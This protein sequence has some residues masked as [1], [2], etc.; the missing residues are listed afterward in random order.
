MGSLTP[1]VDRFM[2]KVRVDE[3]TG[4]WIWTS[5]TQHRDPDSYG[6]F[7]DGGPVR[8]AD[9]RRRQMTLAHRWSYAHFKGPL[10]DAP[11]RSFA[12]CHTCDRPSC[13]NPDHL[14]LGTYAENVDDARRKGRL[15]DRRGEHNG[16]ARVTAD[17]V[18]AMRA[19]STGRHGEV[20][21]FARQY[22]LTSATVSKI[23]KRQ[24]WA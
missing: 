18:A 20:S 7:W 6:L 15:P 21:A 19:A 22:G 13:V 14:F 10:P 8:N 11:S 12:V 4:C 24:T 9:G 23:L 16:R 17:D 3:D 2:A 5:S 1:I